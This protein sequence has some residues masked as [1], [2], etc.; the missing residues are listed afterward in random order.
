MVLSGPW[1]GRADHSAT[2]IGGPLLGGTEPPQLF[3]VGGVSSKGKPMEDAWILDMADERWR[4]VCVGRW[5]W[6]RE[7]DT[8]VDFKGSFGLL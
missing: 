4:M 8:D 6:G 3:V 1:G 5:V 7:G 2:C